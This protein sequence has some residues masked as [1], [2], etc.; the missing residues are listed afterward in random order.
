MKLKDYIENRHGREANRLE[1]EAMN[2]PFLQD[3]IDGFDAMPGEHV[4]HIEKLEKRLAPRRKGWDRRIW[5]GV[6]AALLLL[7]GI[8]L[9]LRQP[10]V[11]KEVNPTISQRQLPV[12]KDIAIPSIPKDTVLL[13]DKV[14]PE[15][16]EEEQKTVLPVITAEPAETV[17]EG[18]ILDETGEPVIGASVILKGGNEGTVT[19]TGGRFRLAVPKGAKDTLLASFVGMKSREI[20]L[21]E[22]VGDIRMKAD[23]LALNETTVVGYGT[24]KKKS[25]TGAAVNFTEN[26]DFGE[27]EFIAYFKKN[28]DTTLCADEPI[29]IQIEFHVNDNGRVSNIRIKKTTCPALDTEVKRLLLGSPRWSRTNR[30]VLLNIDL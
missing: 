20:P 30:K 16:Q 10:E 27:P 23:D 11:K 13:A 3:A 14:E 21:K 7:V 29:S 18:R 5:I 15:P 22:N 17:A 12:E 26:E 2:D 9:L 1:R 19:D 4:S 24:Q 28:Y 25:M 6:A 8:P